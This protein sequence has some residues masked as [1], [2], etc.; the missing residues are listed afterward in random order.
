MRLHPGCLDHGGTFY[1]L[2][3]FCSLRWWGAYLGGGIVKARALDFGTKAM[4]RNYQ[5]ADWREGSFRAVDYRKEN[6]RTIAF[7]NRLNVDKFPSAF[8]PDC[9]RVMSVGMYLEVKQQPASWL[10]RS[11]ANLISVLRVRVKV[12][13]QDRR[14]IRPEV[15][16][17]SREGLT[18]M[19]L[20]FFL[21]LCCCCVR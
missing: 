9:P 5:P 15:V 6:P 2:S 17:R 18:E 13:V 1:D 19:E 8:R 21:L 7:S 20:E 3:P 11:V 12:D 10:W 4:S 16:N 14:R